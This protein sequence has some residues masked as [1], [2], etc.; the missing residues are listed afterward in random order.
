M[1]LMEWT[2]AYSVGVDRFDQDHQ[3]LIRILNEL[4]DA[5]TERRGKIVIGSVLFD[6]VRYT[7][8]HFTAEETAMKRCGYVGYEPH[9][10]EHRVLRQKVRAFVA[11][12][13]SGNALI[14]VDVLWFLR[15]WLQSHILKSDRAYSECLSSL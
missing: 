2:P 4:N 12:Y 15:D 10:E 6:L 9:C 8:R 13:E 11:E 7:E 14:S 3:Q 1:A 5:M